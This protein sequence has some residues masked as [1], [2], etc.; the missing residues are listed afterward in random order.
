MLKLSVTLTD[1][2]DEETQSFVDIETTVLELEH[3][4]AS[5]SKW[6]SI[7]EK[8]F[9]GRTEST[10]EETLSYI[11]CMC[12]TPDVPEEV[13]GKLSN[14]NYEDINAYLNAKMTA[15][16]FSE[17]PG[18]RQSQEVITSE[19]IYYWMAS[20]DIPFETQHWHLNRLLTLIKVF[21]QK[22]EP[23]KKMSKAELA[24]K[25]REENARRKAQMGTRG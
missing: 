13:W 18:Q 17:R 15:T 19:I 22:N 11:K 2:F 14:Q 20:F 23:A 16:W 12:R 21:S 5:L 4:L 7:W 10:T 24:A 25:N 6:E 3:S 1:G 8:P 9:L